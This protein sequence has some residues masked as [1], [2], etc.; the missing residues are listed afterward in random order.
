MERDVLLSRLRDMA[1]RHKTLFH[2]FSF[3]SVLQFFNLGLPLLTY[4]YLIRVMGVTNY[5]LVIFARAFIEFF[6]MVIDF[7]FN[8][9]SARSVSINR[10]DPEKLSEIVS[11]IFTL[12][13]AIFGAC[14][15]VLLVLVAI[16][17]QL[18]SH[19]ELYLLTLAL[20]F[21]GI[22]YPIWFFQGQEKMQFITYV[23]ITS[24]L[25][26]AGLIFVC[27][28]GP[29]DYLWYPALQVIGTFV[30]GIF[31]CYLIFGR[32]DVRLR[33]VKL[34][35]LRR[36]VKEGYTFFLSKVAATIQERTNTLMVGTFLGTTEVAYYDLA[37]KIISIAKIPFYILN[38]TIYPQVARNRDM[39]FV[40]KVILASFALAVVLYLVIA[41]S[42]K[43]VIMI[44]AGK[45]LLA[46]QPLFYLLGLIL[47]V[48]GISYLLGNNMLVVM[49]HSRQS[50]FSEI[51]STI[52]F[53]ITVLILFLGQWVTMVTLILAY[54]AANVFIL[55]YRFYY[56]RTLH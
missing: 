24:K 49:G 34:S 7:G 39:R 27:I 46:A 13:I 47:P 33:P 41:A 48:I 15:L 56:C 14:Y 53:L 31:S 38:E 12:K 25:T 20:G 23:E 18:G 30:G 2:N 54:L 50:N 43:T 17:P 37:N 22:L 10:H 44:L 5:G 42:S 21:D 55:V 45:E 19:K 8:V 3:L 40:K 35:V 11:A 9:P 4:P 36:Y 29:E 32:F 52:F 28:R 6:I 16:V 26:F 51:L 1:S